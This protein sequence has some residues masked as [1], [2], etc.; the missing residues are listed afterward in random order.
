MYCLYC[1]LVTNADEDQNITHREQWLLER[2]I[3][4]LQELIMSRCWPDTDT[5]IHTIQ[6]PYSDSTRI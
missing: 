4:H 5:R 6:L 2:V 3:K 1:N